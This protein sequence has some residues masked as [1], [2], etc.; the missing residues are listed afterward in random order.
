[1]EGVK[2]IGDERERDGEEERCANEGVKM[3]GGGIQPMSVLH[4]TW[5]PLLAWAEAPV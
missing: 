3:D 2:W 1:M 5:G 4:L